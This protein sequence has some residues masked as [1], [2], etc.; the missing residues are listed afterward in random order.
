[1]LWDPQGTVLGKV[2]ETC[3]RL[4][5]VNL[6]EGEKILTFLLASFSHFI[7]V[8]LVLGNHGT[9]DILI[10]KQPH[11]VDVTYMEDQS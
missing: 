4:S 5:G 1:M 7:A 10:K 2:Q 11:I 9:L 6:L 3:L 8:L